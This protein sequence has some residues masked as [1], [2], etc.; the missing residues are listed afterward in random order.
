MSS[1]LVTQLILIRAIFYAYSLRDKETV[2]IC[3]DRC[4]V[5]YMTYKG[6][7]Q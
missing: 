1:D 3:C 5:P 7:K 4:Q 2:Y 6:G